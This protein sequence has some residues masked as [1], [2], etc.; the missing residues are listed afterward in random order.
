MNRKRKR[1]THFR[2]LLAVMIVSG[3][4]LTGCSKSSNPI[5]P[6]DSAELTGNSTQDRGI[7]HLLSYGTINIDPVT[8][9]VEIVPAR[10]SEV[11]LNIRQFVENAPCTDC[12]KLVS[13][14]F[15]PDGEILLGLQLTHPF[16]GLDE[17]TCFDPRLIMMFN[18]S[19]VWP[20]LNAIV[21]RAGLGD[22]EL[23]NADGYTRLFNPV[24]F[25][26]HSM[27]A[28]FWEYSQG[29]LA[30]PGVMNGTLNG[31]RYFP[32][33][34]DRNYLGSTASSTVEIRIVLPLW[35]LEIGYAIDVNW[36]PAD[37][38]STGNPNI[39]DVPDD[40]PMIANMPEAYE[41]STLAS[42]GL[43]DDGTG[44]AELTVKVYDWQDN[45]DQ[46]EV[47]VE[48][49][50]I[51]DGLIVLDY[52]SAGPDYAEF[53]IEIT[54]EKVA[55]IG[56]Y[57]YLIAAK[58][59][60]S[61]DGPLPAIAYTFGKIKVTEPQIQYEDP[62]ALA[63]ADPLSTSVGELI[64]FFDNGSFDPDG[65]D[66]LVYEWD[67]DGDGTYDEEGEEVWH[68]YDQMGTYQVQFRV[69]DDEYAT[70]SLEEPIVI[71]IFGNP[72][73]L[74]TVLD[75]FHSPYCVKVDTVQDACYVDCTQAA[76]VLDFG[77]YKIDENENIT[78]EYEKFGS[79]FQG[80]PGMFGLNVE[81]RKLIA[82]DILG[83]WPIGGPIDLWDL[84]GGPALKFY[85]PIE[86]EIEVAFLWD[87]EL[88]HETNEAV[89][90]E[91]LTDNLVV[92]DVTSPTPIYDFY[93]TN[94]FPQYLEADYEN[95][96]LFLYCMGS[97]TEQPSLMVWDAET[98]TL[99]QSV[100]SDLP[101][102]PF[103]SDLD[104]NPDY[105]QVYFGSGAD[106]FEVWDSETYAHI[107]TISC[108]YGE[109]GGID[110]MW[111][112]IYV[113][114]HD[115]TDGRLLV[116]DAETLEL[117]WDIQL[118]ADAGLLACNPNNGKIYIASMEGQ[119]VMVYQD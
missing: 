82:P 31:Y 21:P 76:P 73:E 54:N 3:M 71:E 36:E 5:I 66:L 100:W 53:N 70:G 52:D 41:L 79:M 32:V 46:A 103:M 107:E 90:A 119:A 57:D 75:G 85:V 64:Y 58:D 8:Q 55:P 105:S 93:P 95:H 9:T 25:A 84:E 47:Q 19:E 63:L 118:A 101:D 26:P 88:F 68:S 23:L 39:I 91:G 33:G 7:S 87:A 86:E 17:F 37:P 115:G 81:A 111:G 80:M 42:E 59:I 38:A 104:Y 99:I 110:H 92:W 102:P 14:Q 96:R 78:K 106:S 1:S 50:D 62:I 49:P 60:T 116:Y 44:S 72:P 15:L 112:S 109:V 30:T 35:E 11:H 29:K 43:Y 48:C 65:G 4:I 40:F 83:I 69:T 51:F 34:N 10:I 13:V 20:E 74:V 24:E 117:I 97:G 6:T 2:D 18:G 56:E 114:T 61:D 113:A 16:P 67:F 27:P 22:G 77:F 98:W 89:I 12:F 94:G 28:R 108:G 45:G